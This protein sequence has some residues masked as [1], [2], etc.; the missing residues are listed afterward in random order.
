MAYVKT[1]KEWNYSTAYTQ[2]YSLALRVVQEVPYFVWKTRSWEVTT[3]SL[4]NLT[5]NCSTLLFL[6]HSWM[7]IVKCG[8]AVCCNCPPEK[9]WA[10]WNSQAYSLNTHWSLCLVFT[11][12][13]PCTCKIYIK[14]SFNLEFQV[15]WDT[16]PY[17]VVN[18]YWHS[19][20]ESS[21]SRRYKRRENSSWVA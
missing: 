18:S 19:S 6:C 5:W 3:V 13:S 12:Q 7:G 4:S 14:I 9:Q 21:S 2:K 15:F 8:G 1:S 16:V 10:T 11:L 17:W 20:S